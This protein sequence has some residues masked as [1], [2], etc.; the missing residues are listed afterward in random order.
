MAHRK[1]ISAAA[2]VSSFPIPAS[3]HDLERDPYNLL[4]YPYDFDDEDEAAR[5]DSFS[6]LVDGLEDGNHRLSTEGGALFGNLD[7]DAEEDPWLD[8]D[9]V[10]ALYTLVRYVLWYHVFH[11]DF[12]VVLLLISNTSVFPQ[13]INI[14]CSRYSGPA[15]VCSM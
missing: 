9:R 5:A 12:V 15:G 14:S 2:S 1:S 8:E 10:Q 3:L 13:K 11:Q 4:P 6:A 7:E